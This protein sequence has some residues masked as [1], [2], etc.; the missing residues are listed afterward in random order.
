MNSKV[1][2]SSSDEKKDKSSETKFI[3]K[4]RKN[5]SE[6]V[7]LI[8]TVGFYKLFLKVFERILI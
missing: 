5:L 3:D 4:F 8:A 2:D 7:L 6:N 1:G